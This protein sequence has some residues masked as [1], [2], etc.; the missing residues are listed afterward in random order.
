[1]PVERLEEGCAESYGGLRNCVGSGS[2]A[3]D[4]ALLLDRFHKRP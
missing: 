2:K 1:M 4:C 3:A